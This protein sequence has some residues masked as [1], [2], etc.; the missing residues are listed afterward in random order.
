MIIKVN[1]YNTFIA[2]GGQVFDPK[3]PTVVFVPGSGLDHRCWAL[4][5]RWFAFHGYSVFAPDFPGH[6]LSEGDPLVS[7]EEMGIWLV[8][9]L[10][11]AGVDSIH[12][13]G[14]SMG[15][16]IA[17]ESA[18]L[19]KGRLKT[20]TAVASATSIPVNEYLITTAE[21]STSSAADL[22]LRWGFGSHAQLGVSAVPGMQ[23]IAIGRQIMSDNPLATDLKACHNYSAGKSIAERVDCPSNVILADEDKMTPSKFGMELASILNA[24]VS[25]IKNSGHMLPME[26][27]KR[28]LDSIKSFITEHTN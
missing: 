2:T 13:V 10:D 16:L 26:S 21:S 3:K 22:M 14:H 6:S 27:P 20:L 23:P 15:F 28:T 12:L 24:K 8:E 11:V 19:L 17:L 5:S 18:V 7:I 9:A 1:K 25:K 4:Q